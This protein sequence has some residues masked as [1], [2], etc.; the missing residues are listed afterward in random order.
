MNKFYVTYP[1]LFKYIKKHFYEM[2]TTAVVSN[3]LAQNVADI[4]RLL[5]TRV[6]WS[7]PNEYAVM[8]LL[9]S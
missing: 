6:G 3:R 4:V 5:F 9:Y 7:V 1:P 2:N 8:L